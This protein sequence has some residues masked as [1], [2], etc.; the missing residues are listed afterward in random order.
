MG[1]TDYLKVYGYRHQYKKIEG[2][3]SIVLFQVSPAPC[4]WRKQPLQQI[5]PPALCT[6]GWFAKT[7]KSTFLLDSFRP[8]L[9]QNF[10][11][12]CITFHIFHIF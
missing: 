4:H 2:K 9:N 10:K 3:K 1:D 7:Q 5:L 11:C 8:F 6:E 12:P